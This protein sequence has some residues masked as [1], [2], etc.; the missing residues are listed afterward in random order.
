LAGVWGEAFVARKFEEVPVPAQQCVG[1]DHVQGVSPATAQ[2][3]QHKQEQS[4]VAME[5]RP[6]VAAL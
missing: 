2:A 6:L 5:S 3:G 1:A 4:V